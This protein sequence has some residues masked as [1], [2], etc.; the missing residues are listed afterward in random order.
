M[1]HTKKVMY[2]ARQKE[3]NL[4]P[5]KRDF[6]L[7]WYPNGL[8]YFLCDHLQ[9]CVKQYQTQYVLKFGGVD[10]RYEEGR[11]ASVGC[12]PADEEAGCL[13][14][15]KWPVMYGWLPWGDCW[16][17]PLMTLHSNQTPHQVTPLHTFYF[18][19]SWEA[20]HRVR[21]IPRRPFIFQ[22]QPHGVKTRVLKTTAWWHGKSTYQL[23]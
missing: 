16:W 12:G 19:R 15:V 21:Q 23:A 6:F 3:T 11:W 18:Y 20:T 17:Q 10:L 7:L 9:T 8:N 14:Y 5:V 22:P 1:Y 13:L 4:Y 2:T